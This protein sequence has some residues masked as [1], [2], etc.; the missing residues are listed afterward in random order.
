M[1]TVGLAKEDTRA[2]DY[3]SYVEGLGLSVQQVVKRSSYDR[4]IACIL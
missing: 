1:T 3:S 2:L 4:V